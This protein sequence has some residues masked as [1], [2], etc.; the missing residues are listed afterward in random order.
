LNPNRQ[1]LLVSATI[2]DELS[3]FVKV[4]L[5]DYAFVKLDSEYTISEKVGLHFILC[6][7]NEKVATILY[8]LLNII[9]KDQSTIIFS[10][11]K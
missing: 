7:A 8:L 9:P 2:P 3:N 11:T 1:T 5:K 10:S 6:K 4:G